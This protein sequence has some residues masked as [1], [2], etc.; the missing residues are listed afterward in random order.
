VAMDIGLN[1]MERWAKQAG[2]LHLKDMA[3]LDDHGDLYLPEGFDVFAVR[4][5]GGRGT[6][7]IGCCSMSRCGVATEAGGSRVMIYSSSGTCLR[8]VLVARRHHCDMTSQADEARR[9]QMLA[10]CNACMSVT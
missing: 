5:A 8:C 2:K 7:C 10:T 1:F 9:L 4:G 3:H 6:L